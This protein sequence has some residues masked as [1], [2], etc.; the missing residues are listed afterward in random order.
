MLL[1]LYPTGG[2]DG[3]L[4]SNLQAAYASLSWTSEASI[5]GVVLS[6]AATV[7]P[8]ALALVLG[9]LL[10]CGVFGSI[11]STG[12]GRMD[13]ASGCSPGET[14]RELPEAGSD[15]DAADELDML[16]VFPCDALLTSSSSLS[17]AW[18]CR[19]LL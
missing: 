14:G 12:V 19:L 10:L 9:G 7:S 6:P 3:G 11:V 1:R 4:R 15:L 2:P 16:L 18:T 13:W 5:L 8:T 17:I